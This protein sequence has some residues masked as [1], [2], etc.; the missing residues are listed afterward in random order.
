M[1]LLMMDREG[2]ARRAVL[3]RHLVMPGL[4]DETA[5]I[6]GWLASALSADTHVNLMAQYRPSH[7][8]GTPGRRGER[9]FREIDRAPTGRE[10]EEAYEAGRRAG[11]RR[12]DERRAAGLF[13]F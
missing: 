2:V 1:G 9:R 7:K 4:P 11:L 8:V 12:F 6:L 3:V 13:R 10:M 5:A